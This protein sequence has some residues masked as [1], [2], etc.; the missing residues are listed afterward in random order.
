M[1]HNESGWRQSESEPGVFSVDHQLDY[2]VGSGYNGL[3]FLIRRGHFLCQAPLSYYART[4]KWDLSPGYENADL[5]FGRMVPE[6]CIN[7][8]AGRPSPV[9]N[10]S[11]AY[12]DPPFQELAI[13]C[14]NCH[15]PAEA[16]VKS[17]GKRPGAIVNPAKLTPRLADNICLNC[18]QAGDARVT[19][20]GKS[21]LDFRPGEWLFDTTVIFKQQ[22]RA[23]QPQAD[24]LEHYAAMQASRSSGRAP[25]SLT[26]LP[27]TIRTLSRARERRLSTTVLSASLATANRVAAFR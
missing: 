14:E 27:A 12:A 22:A 23:D 24:L 9:L 25:V 10:T 18:H 6:E 2:A 11:G 16:H 20:P 21:Y 26:V 15:G 19:Q 13:G 5:G 7:C 17:Q 1:S 3:T 8:H 4:Q